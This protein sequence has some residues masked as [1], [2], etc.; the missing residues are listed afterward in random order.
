MMKCTEDKDGKENDIHEMYAV[1]KAG[2]TDDMKLPKAEEYIRRA[3]EI[4]E[5]YA[6]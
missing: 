3:L 6:V 1:Y 4:D 5:M 2:E